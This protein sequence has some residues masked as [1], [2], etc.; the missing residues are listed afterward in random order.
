MKGQALRRRWLG[1][2]LAVSLVMGFAPAPVSN[3][4]T[5]EIMAIFANHSDAVAKLPEARPS[6]GERAQ[7]PRAALAER[8]G[9]IEDR[10]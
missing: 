5:A 2:A 7:S 1:H 6:Q 3:I 10:E 4:S 8:H 9:S